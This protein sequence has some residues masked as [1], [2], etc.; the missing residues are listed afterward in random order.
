MGVI[1]NGLLISTRKSVGGVNFYKRNGVQCL[2]SKPV[3][4]AGY[5]SSPAQAQQ[6]SVFTYVT[7][8][9]STA[10]GMEP[11]IRG[12]W[13]A[14]VKGK[15]RTAFN[16]WSSEVL[17]AVTRDEAGVLLKGEA[18]ATSIAEFAENPGKVFREKCDLLRS[19]FA[20]LGEGTTVEATGTG[21]LTGV[22]VKVP[23]AVVNAWKASLPT[24]YQNATDTSKDVLYLS[25]DALPEASTEPFLQANGTTSGETVDFTFTLDGLQPGKTLKFAYGAAPAP[26]GDFGQ[27]A[28]FAFGGIASIVCPE[29]PVE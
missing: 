2:R 4:N 22:I 20:D 15:G 19:K 17:R 7:A 27:D 16:N 13:G 8:F 24:S 11:L 25:G 5:V 21:T 12:G 3:R 10:V 26:V 18:R 23:T 28:D 6:N 14:S 9:K 1:I 29:A